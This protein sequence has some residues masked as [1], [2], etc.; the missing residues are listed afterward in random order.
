MRETAMVMTNDGAAI[1]VTQD[2]KQRVGAGFVE[3][4]TLS[5]GETVVEIRSATARKFATEAM[6]QTR[7]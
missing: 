2:T 6:L 5:V 3:T 4:A 7:E 1:A